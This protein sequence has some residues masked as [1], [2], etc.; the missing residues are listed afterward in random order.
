MIDKE[1][2]AVVKRLRR[3]EA[4]ERQSEADCMAELREAGLVPCGG[5]PWTREETAAVNAIVKKHA[6]SVRGY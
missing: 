1:I 5:R 6:R 2:A 3:C 4:E